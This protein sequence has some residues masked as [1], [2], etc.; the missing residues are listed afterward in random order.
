[1]SAHSICE[2]FSCSTS[3]SIRRR[4][5]SRG[6][7]LETVNKPS[8]GNTER[9]PSNGSACRKLQYVSGNFGLTNKILTLRPPPT[10]GRT[11]IHKRCWLL[12]QL[13]SRNNCVKIRELSAE[14]N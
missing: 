5:Q 10:F 9:F 6:N 8:G 14:R 11:A 3:R 13:G 4:S 1:M 12:I 7:R 2:S